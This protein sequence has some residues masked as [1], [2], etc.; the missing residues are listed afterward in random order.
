MESESHM[1]TTLPARA[2]K[3]VDSQHELSSSMFQEW[4]EPKALATITTSV[5]VCLVLLHTSCRLGNNSLCTTCGSGSFGSFVE[6]LQHAG[7]RSLQEMWSGGAGLLEAGMQQHGGFLVLVE[8]LS[9]GWPLVL[10]VSK[11]LRSQGQHFIAW[12]AACKGM[13]AQAAL[14]ANGSPIFVKRQLQRKLWRTCA[15]LLQIARISLG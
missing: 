5:L 13:S 1:F 10:P 8:T 6:E 9:K 15:T 14:V 2:L 12:L 7:T 11:Y 3:P 4:H